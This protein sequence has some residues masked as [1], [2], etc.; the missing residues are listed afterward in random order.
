MELTQSILNRIDTVNKAK[1]RAR[2]E[3]EGCNQDGLPILARAWD[4]V[5][6]ILETD[7]ALQLKSLKGQL[8]EGWKE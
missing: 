7:G 2:E 1:L 5:R 3:A 8:P 6:Q 4:A